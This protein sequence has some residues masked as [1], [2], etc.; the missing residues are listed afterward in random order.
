MGLITWNCFLYDNPEYVDAY[1]A[2]LSGLN[3]L[4][5]WMKEA[6]LNTKQMKIGYDNKACVNL[7][8]DRTILLTDLDRA[9]GEILQNTKI[10]PMD[11]EDITFEW[12]KG[13]QDD[14]IDVSDLPL[15]ALLNIQCNAAAK[16]FTKNSPIHHERP[17]PLPNHKATLYLNNKMVTT[18]LN[19]Q[20][21]YA[22]QAPAMFEYIREKF[23]WTDG[24]CSC[25]NWKAIG[26][27]KKRLRRSSSITKSKLMYGWLNVG[28]QK[29]RWVKKIHALA[30]GLN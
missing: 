5:R 7:L 8:H 17:M 26:T 10:L 27:A 28:S 21:Q 20:I 11:F 13:H 23:E 24:Q 19:E 25:V 2:E 9:H 3:D 15:L 18:K 12:V 16:E 6:G 30:A 4:I 29:R 1:Y 22:A 14:H